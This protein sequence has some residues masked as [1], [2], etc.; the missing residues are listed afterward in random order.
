MADTMQFDLVSPERRLASFQA[1]EVL[2]PGADGDMT[3]MPGHSPVIATLRPGVLR[4]DGPEGTSE[5]IVTGGF[6][7]INAE[8]LSVLAEQA[9][10][11]T[12]VTRE[13]IDELIEDARAKHEEAKSTFKN[14]PGPVD[15]A[16][17]LLSDMVALGDHIA[18]GKGGGPAPA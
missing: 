11:M 2:I 1:R 13:H 9:I 16:A 4:V 3:A 14:E 10:P 5:Y 18:I 7:E 15:D 8:G 6:A 12:E 17:K